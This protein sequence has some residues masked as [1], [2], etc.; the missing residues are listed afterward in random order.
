MNLAFP[1]VSVEQPAN[2]SELKALLFRFRS[3]ALSIVLLSVIL[4]V[5]ALS[6][7]IYL[8]IIYDRVLMSSSI[9][10]L[11]SVFAILVMLYLFQGIFDAMRARLLQMVGEGFDRALA[12]RLQQLESDLAVRRALASMPSTPVRDLDQIRS[13]FLGQGP[14]A[15][16]DLPWILF[17]LVILW[18]LHPLLGITTLIGALALGMVTWLNDRG[19]RDEVDLANRLGRQ[20]GIVAE[21]V[22]HNVDA[23][24]GLAIGERMNGMVAEQ[25]TL[26]VRA[27]TALS[28]SISKYA[29]LGR[30]LRMLVQS[31]VLTAG[32][33]LVIRGEASAGIIF[34]ASILAGRALAPVDQAI[35]NW[36]GLVAARQ[37]WRRLDP[38]LC[39]HPPEAKPSVTLEVPRERV[40]IDRLTIVPPG[41]EQA[42][43]TEITFALKAGD[44]LAVV[45]PSGSGKSSL[46]RAI[47]NIWPA[48]GGTVRLDGAPLDQFEEGHLRAAIGY[49]PQ[50]AELFAG[51]VAQNISRFEPDPSSEQIIAAARAAGI[52]D[53]VLSMPDGYDTLVGDG[54]AVLSAGQRQRV[55]L[56]RAL[57]RDPFLLVL[58]EPDSNLDP[59]GE[60]A[61]AAAISGVRKRGGIVIVVTH[62]VTLLKE[63]S[64][65][66]VMRDGKQQA[67]GPRDQVLAALNRNAAPA[68]T[69]NGDGTVTARAQRK[70]A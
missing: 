69:N 62:R 65:M 31:A 5:L 48:T 64:L 59:E 42:V 7:S 10:T 4:N 28:R 23:I 18:L 50:E 52:H 16:I 39:A 47:V 56:A 35:A 2:E 57:F 11:V 51:T 49:L 40:Q 17:F 1:P 25:H 27:Q 13:F 24:R 46:S 20:R 14:A 53:L 21:R 3:A 34:A 12:G 26:F 58:D 38:L 44:A 45:G 32:A 61:L 15:L 70:G 68:N 8:L 29:A 41:S 60:L 37:A 19:T 67:F 9:Q 55:A 43:V 33:I 63:V 66:L 22:R 54:G 30:G 6:G 36:R